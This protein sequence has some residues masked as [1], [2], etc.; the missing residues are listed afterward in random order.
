VNAGAVFLGKNTPVAVGDYWAGPSHALPTGRAARFQEGLNVRT[1]LKK[2]SFIS[3]S[4]QVIEN[5]GPSIVRFAKVE[6]MEYH[7]RSI[8]ERNK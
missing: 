3:N 5:D 2:I 6:G 4:K 7:A 1:F 8:Q